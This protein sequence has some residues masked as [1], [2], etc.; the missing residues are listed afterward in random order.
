MPE[1]VQP[2]EVLA[3]LVSDFEGAWNCIAARDGAIGRGNLMFAR[4]AM[5][6][7]EWVALL[8]GAD[9]SGRALGALAEALKAINPRYFTTLPGPCADPG[10][11]D[12]PSVPGSPPESQLLWALFDLVRNGLAH[13]YLQITAEL[14]C[15]GMFGVALSGADL[16]LHLSMSRGIHPYLHLKVVRSGAAVRLMLRPDILFLDLR[17]A[18]ERADLLRRG[19]VFP[20]FSR[21]RRASTRRRRTSPTTDLYAFTAD[22]LEA[23]FRAA[24]HV[25]GNS[26]P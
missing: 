25:I 10:W 14:T 20:Y 21:P 19:L 17:D 23:A 2:A 12:L 1:H 7:L 5:T 3:F 11:F 4:H 9:V 26:L 15:G 18:I 6:L 22:E 8:A 13:Q 16:G 24:G